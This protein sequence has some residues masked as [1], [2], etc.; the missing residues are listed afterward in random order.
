MMK[1]SVRVFTHDQTQL[2]IDTGF[3]LSKMRVMNEFRLV[4]YLTPPGLW[5]ERF[6]A[7][8]HAYSFH[9]QPEKEGVFLGGSFEFIGLANIKTPAHVNYENSL[10]A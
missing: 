6:A 1:V 4:L 3:G 9:I 7:S 2:G 5:G 10:P 8:P